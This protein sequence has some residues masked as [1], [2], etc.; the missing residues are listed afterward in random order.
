M[1][2]GPV[3]NNFSTQ[4][5]QQTRA[6]TPSAKTDESKT[7]DAQ[8]TNTPEDAARATPSPELQDAARQLQQGAESQIKDALQGGWQEAGNRRTRTTRGTRRT[9][10]GTPTRGLGG[11]DGG[12]SEFA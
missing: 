1:T 7:P 6:V 3:N 4:Q 2:L 9:A 11:G 8:P 5:T 10:Q 12:G